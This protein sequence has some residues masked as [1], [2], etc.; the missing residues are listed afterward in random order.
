MYRFVFAVVAPCFGPEL[1]VI[2][3][4]CIPHQ[5]PTYFIGLIQSVLG[6]TLGGLRFSPRS[7]GARSPARSATWIV[8]QGV[9]KGVR[10][11]TFTPSTMGA[12]E[13]RSVRFSM[14]PPTRFMRA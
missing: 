11:R 7:A 12:S 4:T 1:H 6:N 2:V 3:L 9:W 14:R 10:R 5:I 13:A 8:R